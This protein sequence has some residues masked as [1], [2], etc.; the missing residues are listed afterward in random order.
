LANAAHIV[1]VLD[2]LNQILAR[3]RLTAGEMDLQHADLGKLGE[4]LLPFGG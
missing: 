3:G 4:D 2:K 1:G